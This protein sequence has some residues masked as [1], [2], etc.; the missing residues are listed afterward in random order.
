MFPRERVMASLEEYQVSFSQDE[1]TEQLRGKLAEFYAQRTLIKLSVTPLDCAEAICWLA[2]DRSAKT[3]GH[4]LP[5][6]GGLVEAFL[7]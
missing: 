5:V 4:I 3:T 7:R 2:S 1:T 6:D